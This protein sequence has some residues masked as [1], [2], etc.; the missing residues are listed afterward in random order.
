M[1]DSQDQLFVTSH[2]A[3]DLLQAAALFK[4]ERL[5]VWEYVANGLQY[6]EPG[7]RA[8]VKVTV[9]N[10]RKRITIRDNGRGMDWEGLH[11]F[12]VMHGENLDR[13][14]GASGRG[15]FGTG[16]SAAF[17]IASL[18]RIT[19]IRNNRRSK[20]ELDRE[21]VQAMFTGDEIPVRVIEREVRTQEPNGTLVEIE[22]IHLRSID[23]AG[24]IYYIERHLARWPKNSAVFVNNHE[25]EISEPPVAEEKVFQ[26]TGAVK[27]S[28]GDVQLV[29]KVSK[30]PLQEDERGVSIYSKG[31]WYETTLA[32]SEGREMSQYIFG[33]IDVPKLEEDSS[34]IPPFDMSRSMQLNPSNDLV[35]E[36]YG[37]IH[38]KVEE[39]RRS[40][41]DAERRRKVSEEARKLAAQAAE[42]ARV[43]NEDFESFRNKVRKT[44]SK[45]FGGSDLYRIKDDGGSQEHDVVPGSEVPAEELTPTGGSGRGDGEGG[46]GREPPDLKPLLFPSEDG[47]LKGQAVGGA[48]R[49]QRPRGGFQVKFDQMGAE[50]NRAKYVPDERTIYVNLNHPQLAAAKGTGPMDDPVF[51]RLAYEVAFTEYAVALAMELAQLEGYYIE[52]MDS[53]IDISETLNRLAR[54]AAYL[55]AAPNRG[56]L[57]S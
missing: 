33:A 18:M 1:P 57:L 27:D 38:E 45:A 30:R 20:V 39:T 17:G 10:R 4:N 47:E 56:A 29:I 40:L 37:F 55:Y 6:V 31:V 48:G 13:K 19:T 46:T 22:N 36:I 7:T 44:Q 54:K 23:Q 34:P 9:D 28:L 53:I 50:S 49:K 42:I 43:I 2:V 41:V 52:A 35:R 26:T 14:Q 51:R 8:V 24:I 3:R 25:C 21:N 32:G 15:R 12:F 16:K 11:N 5:A